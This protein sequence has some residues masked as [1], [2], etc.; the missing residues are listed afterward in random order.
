MVYG[1]ASKDLGM[2]TI[3]KICDRDDWE[4]ALAQ[5]D[6]A[7]SA[8][9]VKDG[10]I[11]FSTAHQLR[12]TARR[13]FAGRHGLV[14]LAVAAEALGGDLRWEKSRGG[15]LFPHLYAPLATR[16]VHSAVPL[17]WRDIAHDFPADIPS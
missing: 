4:M 12:E 9:D 2:P 11:H 16:H 3:Y 1:F 7:G 14:L 5:G 8:V 13:H 15:D 6:F 10:Y 17:P